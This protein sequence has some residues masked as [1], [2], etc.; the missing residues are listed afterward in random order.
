MLLMLWDQLAV[1]ALLAARD[2]QQCT[3]PEHGVAEKLATYRMRSTPL[4]TCRTQGVVGR[5]SLSS[6]SWCPELMC[7]TLHW[8]KAVVILDAEHVAAQGHCGSA[9]NRVDTDPMS[10]LLTALWEPASREP[11]MNIVLFRN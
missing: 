1:A 6:T 7:R 4:M 9:L 3:R 5:P 10:G 11:V 2:G 8:L